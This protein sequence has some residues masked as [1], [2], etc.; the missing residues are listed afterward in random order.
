M[1]YRE[2]RK[3]RNKLMVSAKS[4]SVS[5]VAS[6]QVVAGFHFIASSVVNKLV[7]CT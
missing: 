4:L 1:Y 2:H 5:S 6:P 7:S 3:H